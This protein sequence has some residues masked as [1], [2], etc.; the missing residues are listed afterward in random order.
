MI[1]RLM[2]VGIKLQQKCLIWNSNLN[3]S[4]IIFSIITWSSNLW[5]RAKQR[6]SARLKGDNTCAADLI[7]LLWKKKLMVN[8]WTNT[9][10]KVNVIH[11]YVQVLR[12]RFLDCEILCHGWGFQNIFRTYMFK[13]W[14]SRNLCTS[15]Q[16]FM[17]YLVEQYCP[18]DTNLCWE[19]DVT[20]DL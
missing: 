3:S 16:L 13:I 9:R 19:I 12:T 5:I 20:Q 17:F 4:L 11:K 15:E 14:R 2:I 18:R 6:A 1:L 10:S 8:L 7:W